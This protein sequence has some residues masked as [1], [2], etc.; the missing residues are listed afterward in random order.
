MPPSRIRDTIP[1]HVEHAVLTAL[2]KLPADRFSTAN[3]AETTGDSVTYW[4]HV[5]RFRRVAERFP[6]DW[7]AGFQYADHLFHAGLLIGHTNAEARAALQHTVDLNPKLAPMWAHLA[8]ASFSHDSAQAAQAVKS[9]MALGFFKGLP[10]GV[11]LGFRLLVSAGGQ[12]SLAILDSLAVF[13]AQSKEPGF[14][15]IGA[16]FL[17]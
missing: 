3:E 6:A 15:R 5:D 17:Q 16:G 8:G 12:L 7:S 13:N 9:L 10:E 1:P 11:S 2:Q 14:H 4:E